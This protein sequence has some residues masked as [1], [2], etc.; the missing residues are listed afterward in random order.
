MIP[1]ITIEGATAT[2]KTKLALE[3]A[4]RLNTEIISADSRQVY[5][6]LNIGTAKPSPEELARVKHHL[7]D[8]ITPD[9]SYNA[10][11]FRKQVLEI[12]IRLWSEGKIPLVCGGTGLYVKALLEGLFQSDTHDPEVR[13]QLEEEFRE[14]GLNALY[15]ELE[16]VDSLTAVKV[17]RNDKQR[18]LRALEVFRSTG[19]PISEHWDKQRREPVFSPYRICLEEERA[20]LYARINE[21]VLGMLQNGLLEEIKSV[22]SQGYFWQSPGFNSVGYKEFRPILEEGSDLSNC[23]VL[24]QQHTRNY[25]KRQVTWYK[26]CKF[27]LAGPCCSINLTSIETALQRHIEITMSGAMNG[28]C[29]SGL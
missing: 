9:E 26:K 17:S 25:A 20:V 8:I 29:C 15:E 16:E 12:A 10:G 1:L 24:A 7:V 28:N 13:V 23:A 27:N 4:E 14:R 21:R 6:C 2:G 3:L 18:I 11:L 19:I 22:L 5:Q